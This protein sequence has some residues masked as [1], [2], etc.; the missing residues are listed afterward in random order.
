[1]KIFLSIIILGLLSWKGFYAWRR[2]R[3]AWCYDRQHH[4]SLREYLLGN[5]ATER[6]AL[7]PFV[8]RALRR[9]FM[10]LLAQ[11][12]FWGVILV[13]LVVLLCL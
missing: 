8:K 4:D 10:P 2:G 7:M 6:E 12:R 3:N 9:A 5:G 13:L 11:W 1:M